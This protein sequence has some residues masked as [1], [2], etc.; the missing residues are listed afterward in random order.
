M[1]LLL[2]ILHVCVCVCVCVCVRVRVCV[3]VIDDNG[4][5]DYGGD[6]SY[7][8]RQINIETIYLNVVQ[9]L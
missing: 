9:A 7:Y 3:C 5:D 8:W 2:M 4:D 1:L 6:G